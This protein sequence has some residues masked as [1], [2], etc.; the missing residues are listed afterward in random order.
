[1]F[2]LVA[3]QCKWT[4]LISIWTT[5]SLVVVTYRL[6]QCIQ[7]FNHM[8]SHQ[9]SPW[10]SVFCPPLCKSQRQTLHFAFIELNWYSQYSEPYHSAI[11]SINNN[12]NTTNLQSW[13]KLLRKCHIRRAFFLTSSLY[14]VL[15]S[16][17]PLEAMLLCVLKQP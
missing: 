1:M 17:L 13:T 2:M 10:G 6:L 11:H 14:H 7:Q 12:I 16:P 3:T 8:G 5:L 15:P 4:S 9:G